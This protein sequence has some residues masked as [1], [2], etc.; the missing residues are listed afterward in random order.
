MARI[1]YKKTYDMVSHLWIK[2]WL[3]LFGVSENNVVYRELR[4]RRTRYQVRY[5]SK[6]SLSPLLFVLALF[7]LSSI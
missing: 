4:F 1:D 6:D 5:F 7:K 3:E 2:V